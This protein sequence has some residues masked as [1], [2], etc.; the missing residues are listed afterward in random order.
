MRTDGNP[1]KLNPNLCAYKTHRIIMPVYIP[2]EEGYYRDAFKIFTL[3]VNSLLNTISLER[4][5]ITIINNASIEKVDEFIRGLQENKLIDQYIYNIVNRGKADAIIGAAKASYEP[6][7]TITDADVLFQPGWIQELETAYCNNPRAGNICPYPALHL[8]HYSNSSTWAGNLFQ[9]KRNKVV[10]TDTLKWLSHTLREDM[11][12]YRDLNNQYYIVK[13]GKTYLLGA[14]HFVA[15]YRRRIFDAL[16]KQASLS[17][18]KGGL[19][20][21]V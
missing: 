16:P 12:E 8:R 7:I 6:L 11:F 18:L 13:G 17:G 19:A 2:N 14:G 21:Q 9:V 20:L 15:M 3:S 10:D 4:T 1:I 5:N